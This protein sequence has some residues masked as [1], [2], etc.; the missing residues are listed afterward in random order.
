MVLIMGKRLHVAKEYKVRYSHYERFNWK[1]E[2]FAHLMNILG[3]NF[4]SGRE[5]E[6]VWEFEVTKEDWRE[7]MRMLEDDEDEAIDEALE[8]LEIDRV[9]ALDIF[10][11]YY[12]EAES[13]SDFMNFCFF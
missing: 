2:E 1:C 12:D 9:D 3:I 13:D 7:G 4:I 8:R 10:E 6:G 11:T 5:D